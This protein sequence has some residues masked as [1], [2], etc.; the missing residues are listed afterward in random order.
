MD[1]DFEVR[2]ER[3]KGKLTDSFNLT[4]KETTENSRA[5]KSLHTVNP[6]E[7]NPDRFSLIQYLARN[8]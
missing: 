6:A 4:Q 7:D 5:S 8:R 2:Y 3:L 1:D